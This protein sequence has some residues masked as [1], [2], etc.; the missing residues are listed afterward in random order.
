[1]VRTLGLHLLQSNDLVETPRP[2]TV[3]ELDAEGALVRL[4]HLA[5]DADILAAIGDGPRLVAVDAPL[6][7]PNEGGQRDIE[8]LLAWC[9]IPVFP[10][11]RRRL[12]QVHGGLRG[13][14]L[15]AA[16]SAPDVE[17]IETSPELV[18]RELQ[19]EEGTSSALDLEEYRT[20]WIAERPPVYRPKGPGRAKPAGIVGA[21]ALL[22]RH[23][24]LQGWVPAE[25]PDD[26]AA[27]RDAAV[28][29]AIAC[30]YVAWRAVHQPQR[31]LRIG[32]KDLGEM[33]LPVDG[34]LAARIAVNLERL[35]GDGTVAI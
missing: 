22:A 7:V 15:A 10:V 29:D 28:L 8:R 2:S 4:E 26:W 3:A 6:A 25:S 35:R 33:L 20:R 30:A 34:N 31:V 11:S 18:L 17:L 23:V 9:D 5:T 12:Q 14:A 24:D 27:I 32:A 21:H 13:V 1:V 16:L 19:W